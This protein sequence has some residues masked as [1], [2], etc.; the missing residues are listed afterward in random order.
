MELKRDLI[1]QAMGSVAT[2]TTGQNLTYGGSKGAT[3]STVSTAA[4]K[5][6]WVTNN[7]D[8]IVYGKLISNLS[9]GDHTTSLATIDTTDDKMNAALVTLLKRRAG[10][11]DP[12]I[13]PIIVRED[14]PWYVLFLGS[15]AFRDLNEDSTITQA[16]REARV[17]G[18]N[19]GNPIFE[20]GDLIYNSVIIREIPEI[21]LFI[22]GGANDPFDGVWGANA[23]SDNLVTAGNGSSRVGIGFFCGAQAIT[24]GRG[25]KMRFTRDKNDDYDFKASVGVEM[26]HDF[27]KNFYNL[28]Q[29]G[30]ITTF[31]SAA[32]DS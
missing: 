11:A 7:T 3:N 4:E 20:G 24:F 1:I 13:R 26:K 23:T 29:H 17:R 2:A 21:D 30:M 22:D 27:I 31:H 14:E 32:A 5:D 28:K 8:R 12:L 18:V 19:T 16:N 9:S 10:L 6:T 25:R 15:L